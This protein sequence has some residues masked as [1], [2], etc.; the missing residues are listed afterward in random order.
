[1]L[2]IT[3]KIEINITKADATTA[4]VKLV[5]IEGIILLISNIDIKIKK[6]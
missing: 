3:I 1:M 2:T 4:I 5:I 6:I